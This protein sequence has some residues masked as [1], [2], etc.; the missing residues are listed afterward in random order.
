MTL[1]KSNWPPIDYEDS[2]LSTMPMSL[3]A[4]PLLTERELKTL[5]SQR[6]PHIGKIIDLLWGYEEMDIQF[7]K[8]GIDDRGGRIGFDQVILDVLLQLSIIHQ[9]TF[10]FDHTQNKVKRKN[11]WPDGDDALL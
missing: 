6:H 4:F 9:R 1:N 8:W 3:D 2:E 11:I 7:K 5:I 10:K